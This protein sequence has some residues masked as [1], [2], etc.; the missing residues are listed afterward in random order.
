M[1]KI[2]LPY[3]DNDGKRILF[4]GSS[5][6]GKN[7]FDQDSRCHTGFLKSKRISLFYIKT[8]INHVIAGKV[9]SV[10]KQSHVSKGFP[11]QIYEN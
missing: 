4:P 11:L 6:F 10:D 5:N 1:E 9:V 8:E 3:R 2:A 7:S